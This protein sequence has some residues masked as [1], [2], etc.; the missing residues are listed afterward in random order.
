MSGASPPQAPETTGLQV[1]HPTL[2]LDDVVDR[3]AKSEAAITSRI[4]AY[5]PLV[6]VYIQNLETDEH[7]GTIPKADEYFLGQ[8]SWSDTEGP[9]LQPLSAPKGSLR[10]KTSYLT[11][12]FSAQYLPDGFAAMSVPDW[13]LLD[14]KRYEFTYVKREFLGEARCL[15]FDVH[16]RTTARDGFTG[17]IWVEDRDYNIVRFNGINRSI[18]QTLT[19]F[20]R[21]KLSFHVDSWRVNALPSMW[22]P[23]Y[24]YCEETDASDKPALPKLPKLKSQIR[25]WGY[26]SRGNQQQQQFTS[27][28]IDHPSISDSGDPPKQLSPVLSQRRWEQEAEENVTARLE[29]AGLLAQIGPVDKVLETVINNLEVT[30]G[31]SVEPIRCRVLLTSPLESFTMGHTIVLS[32]GLIDTLPD[33]ASLAM[34]LAHELAHIVLGH[35][36][37]DTKFAFAD[38]LM[39]ADGEL[40]NRLRFRHASREETEADGK[41]IEMLKNSPYKDRLAESGLFLRAIAAYSKQLVNLIQPHMGDHIADA[42]QVLRLTELMDQ[43]PALAPERLDQIGALPLG[44]RLIVDPWSGRVEFMKSAAVPLTSAREKAT[45]AVTPLMPYVK[46]AEARAAQTSEPGQ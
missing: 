4:R 28:Q 7:L 33:E 20:F 13:R 10:Q 41:V 18:D 8:F 36:L 30:N 44:A 1:T 15:V 45:F 35:Q 26:E 46:Y 43:A 32:R 29:K 34:M 37:I 2:T 14:G 23:V 6:E 16:P 31:L 17:R 27:I 39:V 24:V 12:P 9:Q 42:G 40:L 11:H 19:G 3:V 22:L 25:I 38:R 21:K 5:H